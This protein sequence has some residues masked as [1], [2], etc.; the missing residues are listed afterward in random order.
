MAIFKGHNGEQIIKIGDGDIAIGF[1]KLPGEDHDTE[2][3][4]AP[5]PEGRVPCPPNQDLEIP[6]MIGKM[7]C[8]VGVVCRI[9]FANAEAI[10]RLVQDLIEFGKRF[11]KP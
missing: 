2:L 1:A 6:E 9:Q 5:L 8:D 3:W 11:K 4:F 10:Y 7:S